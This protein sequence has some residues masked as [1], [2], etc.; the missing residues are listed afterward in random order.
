MSAAAT[1]TVSGAADVPAPAM[2][3][4]VRTRL[5]VPVAEWPAIIGGSIAAAVLAAPLYVDCSFWLSAGVAAATF[6]AWH[7]LRASTAVPWFP[8]FIAFVA[9][10]QWVLAPWVIY[11]YQ[12]VASVAPMAVDS[13][14]Y[15]RFAVPAT[16][17]LLVGMYLPLWRRARG[18]STDAAKISVPASFAV[19]CD[20]M[21]V[22]GIIAKTVLVPVTPS[23]LRF[24]AQLV[25]N[26][27]WV[28]AFGLLLAGARGWKQRVAAVTAVVALGNVA[29]L[30]FLDVLTWAAC[31]ALLLAFRYKP[32]PRVVVPSTLVAVVL[33][34]TLQAFKR[35]HRDDI[36]KMSLDRS[37]RAAV[38]G[39]TIYGLLRDPSLILSPSNV[40]ATFDRLNEGY[41][42]SRVLA[43][44]PSGEPFARGETIAT[45]LRSAALPRFLDPDKYVAG[46]AEI[47]PRFTGMELLNG[48][49]IGLSVPG[50]L[51]GN[52][53]RGGAVAGTFVY[54]LLL[55]GIVR[56]F[57]RRARRASVWWAWA[58]F[59]LVS[60]MSAEQNVGE[61]LNQIVKSAVVM[62]G[63]LVFTPAWAEL[64]RGARRATRGSR[65]EAV[66]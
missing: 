32:R 38:T 60:S 17:A 5:L 8:G 27:A 22:G 15:F 4:P 11:G 63:V 31:L 66:P 16:L 36:R 1:T 55:G 51:Y 2:P 3:R 34:M 37:A 13:Q 18:P 50:E 57:L 10:L 28:G 59:M 23:S 49:S 52:F 6:V 48:T 20:A 45:A 24:V 65:A 41:I 19:T 61:T 62:W 35:D 39:A 33:F 56:W 25:G 30:Q 12:G 43:W 64:R 42:I 9:V 58:P 54:G 44:V 47:V 14:E 26:L 7:A 29:D 21:V 40:A 53:G 46:G